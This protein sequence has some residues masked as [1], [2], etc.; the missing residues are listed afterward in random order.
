LIRSRFYPRWFVAV[1]VLV[2]ALVL[3]GSNW[4]YRVQ[5]QQLR[6][7][8]EDKLQ[9]IVQLKKEQVNTWRMDRLGD[10]SVLMENTLFG[11][12]L[13]RLMEVK[14]DPDT[15]SILAMFRSMHQHNHYSDV[16]L[17]DP[18]G[19]M[20][21]SLGGG[22]DQIS[23]HL[24]QSLAVAFEEQR[25]L[26]TDFQKGSNQ[27]PFIAVITPFFTHT[28]T[29]SE[30]LAAVILVDDPRQFLYPLLQ[31]WPTPSISS[32]TQLVRREGETVLFLNELRHWEGAPLTFSLPLDDAESPVA[33]AAMGME[34]VFHGRD[35]RGVP[36]LAALTAI[37]DSHWFLV[38]KVDEEEILKIWRFRARMIRL[39]SL[40]L[41]I[42]TAA[43]FGTVWQRNEKIQ[44]QN[45]SQA[46]EALR[47]IE[48]MLKP[49]KPKP[50]E[51][52]IIQV[53][54]SCGDLASL[55]TN[56]VILDSVGVDILSDIAGEYLDLLETSITI[57]EKNGD[58]AL[59]IFASDWCKTLSS[60]P[61]KLGRTEGKRTALHSGRWLCRDSC[62]T[63]SSKVSI[64][65]G[66]PVDIACNGGIHIYSIPI[67]AKGRVVGS[68]SVSYGDPPR[69]L[70]ELKRLAQLYEVDERELEKHRNAYESRPPFIIEI[71][72]E[73]LHRSARL[74]GALIERKQAEDEVHH[75]N[76]ALE[77]RTLQLEDSNKELGAFAYSVA[78]D[79]RSP[80]RAV[81]G[82]SRILQE[83]YAEAFDSEG[84]RLLNVVRTNTQQMDRLITDLLSLTR[85]ARVN[86][87]LSHVD[88]TDLVQSVYDEVAT[89]E[90]QERIEFS[91]DPLPLVTGDPTLIR[92]V[93][94]NLLDNAI[95]FTK[96]LEKGRI[97]IG[98][99][100][101]DSEN[102]YFVKDN[103][104][105]FD[106]K[107]S[108]K[109]FGVFQRLHKAEDFEGTG[110]GLA[111]VQRIVRRHGG[112]VWAEGD[113]NKGAAFYFS[114]P[115]KE[116]H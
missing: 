99:W 20:R 54:S 62:W 77:R 104:V 5:E 19:Q 35:Y 59:A 25:P 72:K 10:A 17:V 96:L 33:R 83:D 51:G 53:A 38:S 97:Q 67:L 82:F 64:R 63:G 84:K 22:F 78:H 86:M 37:P 34:G 13:E 107:Y 98:G 56:R 12:M 24:P 113:L 92:Q 4:F 7:D 109:L 89:A 28:G 14:G 94:F 71:A 57:Y 101:G 70:E 75:L 39:L 52:M 32:E 73:R 103:G 81:D 16:I 29:G 65:T 21:L 40:A 1:L 93:W 18:G 11:E 95:K 105:G 55:N 23:E 45:I 47:R 8:A 61:C 2:I 108:H 9:T 41:V 88:M 42:S 85:S 115:N 6:Q 112:R 44:F 76:E 90:V 30:P 80:L 74:I 31:S 50:A 106:P 87:K 49:G 58:C 69:G 15:E 68:I 110:I 43:V 114:L 79:L 46:R 3:A 102:T 116:A 27:N 111:I 26:L 100:S 60:A 91:A 36:V 66:Q 48:W